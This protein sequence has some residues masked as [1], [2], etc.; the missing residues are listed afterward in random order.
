MLRCVYEDLVR[1]DV[2]LERFHE[3]A[4]VGELVLRIDDLPHLVDLRIVSVSLE[5]LGITGLF[6]VPV[7]SD[8]E[9]CDLVHR[10]CPDLHFERRAR[11]AYDSRVDGL[12]F[13][14]LRHRDIVLEAARNVL[15]HLV[16]DTKYLIAFNDFVYDYPAREK[17]IDLVD[18]LT[19]LVHLL[20]DAVEM[21][22]TAFNVVMDN[23]V[24]LKFCADL[25]DNVFH[26]IFSL[27]AVA[28]NELYELIIIVR[29]QITKTQVLKLPLDLI[30]TESACERNVD[31]KRFLGFFDLLLRTHGLQ[32]PHVVQTVCELYEYDSDIVRKRNEHLAHVG[33]LDVL[34][35]V[36]DNVI[37]A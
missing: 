16:D 13:V 11:V 24:L 7:G 17:V 3:L 19:L 8:T 25:G 9:L 21:L 2:H 23:A 29:M 14:L 32:S 18:R 6:V 4:G 22:R 34:L 28:V 12:V 10:K 37:E 36:I 35:G 33:C 20:I 27:R 1:R 30:D 31:I 26:E 5:F 15:V